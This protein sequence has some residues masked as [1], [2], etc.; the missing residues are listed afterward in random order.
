MFWSLFAV[1]INSLSAEKII[2]LSIKECGQIGVSIIQSASGLTTG[3]P[4][5]MEYAVEPVGVDII[6][7][8][9]LIFETLLPSQV[10]VTSISLAKLPLDTTI[11]L[12]Q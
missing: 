10:I 1:T 4:A 6:T 5:A 9:L 12:R 2:L 8:S 7:P 11:S 3:P